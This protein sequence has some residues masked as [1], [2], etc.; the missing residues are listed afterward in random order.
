MTDNSAVIKIISE[1][2][3]EYNELNEKYVDLGKNALFYKKEYARILDMK[4]NVDAK[5]KD[6]RKLLKEAQSD[7][8]IA[9]ESLDGA[10]REIEELMDRLDDLGGN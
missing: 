9:Q 2:T 10:Q 8:Q 1:H 5:N 6:L 7:C 3:R 4:T